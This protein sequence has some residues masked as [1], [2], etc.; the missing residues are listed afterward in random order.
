MAE[1]APRPYGPV[2]GWD[3]RDI[4]RDPAGYVRALIQ[5][6]RGLGEQDLAEKP[7]YQRWYENPGFLSAVPKTERESV[8]DARQ[9]YVLRHLTANVPPAQLHRLEDLKQGDSPLADEQVGNLTRAYALYPVNKA[10]L[11]S[12]YRT[13]GLQGALTPGSAGYAALEWMDSFPAMAS[14]GSQ[15]LADSA[16]AYVSEA[17]GGKPSPRYPNAY[18]DFM[19]SGQTY[20]RPFGY[21]SPAR[22]DADVSY[23]QRRRD[24]SRGYDS[25]MPPDA[26]LTYDLLG[27]GNSGA[28][29]SAAAM[30]ISESPSQDEVLTDS[31]VPAPLAAAAGTLHSI[32]LDPFSAVGGAVRAARAGKSARALRELAEEGGSYGAFMA[33]DAVQSLGEMRADDMP[34][35]LY[36]Q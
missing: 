26:W 16:D 14:A 29:R 24:F 11:S 5:E 30:A 22:S 3:Q 8:D 33:N 32:V 7:W 1:F 25:I 36:A 2:P 15:M 13:Y 28:A 18:G 23:A 12:D 9:E 6:A 20:L 31:G 4:D 27:G 21:Q 34:R 35:M 17:S 19:A 10:N